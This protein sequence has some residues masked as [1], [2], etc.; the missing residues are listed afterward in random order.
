MKL[1]WD[2]RYDKWEQMKQSYARCNECMPDAPHEWCCKNQCGQFA[3]CENC[4]A[5]SREGTK[6]CEK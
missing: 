5:S 1:T 3:Y 2:R 6:L 4:K